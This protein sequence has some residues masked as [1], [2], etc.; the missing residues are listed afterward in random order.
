MTLHRQVMIGMLLL[1]ACAEP[2]GAK[3]RLGV[4]V[5]TSAPIVSVAHPITVTVTAT[6][7]GSRPVEVIANGCPEAYRVISTSGA[8][9]APGPTF[10]ALI[11]MD[12]RLQPGERIVFSYTWAGTTRPSP[13]RPLVALPAGAYRLQGVVQ[14]YDGEVSSDPIEVRVQ[15]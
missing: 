5:T 3:Q 7:E 13:D 15:P 11:G 6:N 4:S 10:C 8:T 14:T 1:G 2:T 12:R 9:V